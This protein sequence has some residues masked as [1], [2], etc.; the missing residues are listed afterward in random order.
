MSLNCS[1]CG[2]PK[3]KGDHVLYC[4]APC[5]ACDN[6]YVYS[7]HIHCPKCGSAPSEHEVKNY[8][9]MWH[10]GDVHCKRCDTFVRYWDAG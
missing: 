8:D 5:A 3:S 1:K 2:D 6:V 4:P 7:N 10:E 9:M